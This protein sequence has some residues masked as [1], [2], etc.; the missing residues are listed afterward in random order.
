MKTR[1]LIYLH[2]F[3]IIF[4]INL[5]MSPLHGQEISNKQIRWHE[6]C[7]SI[8]VFEITNKE[9]LKFLKDGSSDK[10]IKKLLYNHVTTFKGKW[11]NA[12]KQGHFIYASITKNSVNY[13]YMPIIPFQVF[14]FREYGIL[15][16]QVIDD[17]GEIRDNAKVKIQNGKW[18]LFDTSIPYD[19]ESKVY[20]TDDWSENPDRILTVEC[21]KFTAVFDL[22]KH[23]IRPS[24]GS[25]YYGNSGDSGPD[26]FSYM[27]TDKNKYK[28]GEKVRFKSY[29]L[30]GN[31]RPIKE[32]LELWMEKP[33]KYYDYKKISTIEPYN[34]G[35]FAG[36]LN[37]EDSLK[38]RLD[39]P[40][41]LQL[42]DQKGRVIAR[43]SFQYEDYELYDNKIETK[44]K[45]FT[46]YYP[47]ENEIEIKVVDVNN[48]IMPDMKANI[49][50]I[51]KN[52]LNS[53]V[54]LLVMPNIIKSD[55]INLD[56]DKTT[57]YK[58]PASLFDKT[59]CTYNVDISVLT[60]DGQMLKAS[61]N[62]A[63]Y[64]SYYEINQTI[65]D[66]TIIFNFN[67]LTRGAFR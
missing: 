50:I 36:E 11:E 18:R 35:G 7:D 63:F 5:V 54:E 53:Y 43:T 62:I 32:T 55:T 57:I 67:E 33:D 42:R 38:L 56:N 65:K 41:S 19:A 61:H 16:L 13:R 52:V 12:P 27:I 22:T 51:R 31:K 47:N 2:T 24:Y 1:T 60:P 17:K 8:F 4:A 29:A 30:T 9:A 28:P 6:G 44:L 20:R 49:N 45:D 66:S 46:Q 39:K 58:I 21:N 3:F 14:L 48:L 59:D 37:L 26:F 64:K 34:P 25:S 15:T 40:Y 10:L 23:V